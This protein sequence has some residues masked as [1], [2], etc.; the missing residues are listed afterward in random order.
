MD[1]GRGHG[2]S[3]LVTELPGFSGDKERVED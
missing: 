3:G 1:W 2:D